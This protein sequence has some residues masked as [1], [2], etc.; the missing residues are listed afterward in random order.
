MSVRAPG[1]VSEYTYPPWTGVDDWGGTGWE[2]DMPPEK[3]LALLVG[4]LD[5]LSRDLAGRLERAD[6]DH[7]TAEAADRRAVEVEAR[8][9]RFNN[10][11]ERIQAEIPRAASEGASRHWLR[12]TGGRAIERIAGQSVAALASPTAGSPPAGDPAQDL[13]GR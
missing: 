3:Q 2:V 6:G 9:A 5:S 8:A 7:L 10:L 12:H 11:F 13:A 1:A 4:H